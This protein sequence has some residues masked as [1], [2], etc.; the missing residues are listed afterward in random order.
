MYPINMM[1][2]KDLKKI[3]NQTI[4]QFKIHILYKPVFSKME[5]TAFDFR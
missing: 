1:R 2:K 5:I 4:L 3:N